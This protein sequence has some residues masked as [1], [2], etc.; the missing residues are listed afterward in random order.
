[1]YII[2]NNLQSQNIRKPYLQ[3]HIIILKFI[4]QVE[5]QRVQVVK[6]YITQYPV[7]LALTLINYSRTIIRYFISSW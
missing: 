4:I 6:Q 5:I 1:M 2:K 7:I 3:I